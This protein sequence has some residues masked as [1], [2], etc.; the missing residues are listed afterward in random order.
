MSEKGTTCCLTFKLTEAGCASGV[1]SFD[2][3][4]I[5]VGACDDIWDAI[6]M[7]AV[8]ASIISFISLRMSSEPGEQS[9]SEH[10]AAVQQS[11]DTR[12]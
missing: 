5:W 3:S 12:L 2:S 1:A 4:F 9:R 6:S 11:S 7:D 10:C 8:L